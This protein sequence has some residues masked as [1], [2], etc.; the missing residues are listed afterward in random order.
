MSRNTDN[1]IVVLDIGSSWT[2]VMAADVN[3]GALRYC[4]HGIVESAGMRKG[5][6]AE[7]A[8][9]AKAVKAASEQAE[10]FSRADIGECVV[11]IGGP[12]IRGLNT[13]GG[14]ELGG[15]MR[16]ID[17]EAVRAAVSRPATWRYPRPGDSSSAAA[18]VHSRRSTGHL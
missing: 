1:L 13:S 14:I 16:E 2:R 7:L 11:G 8:P 15:R 3:D 17:K 10:Y 5:L 6:I 18:P 12:H 9:A 4:G